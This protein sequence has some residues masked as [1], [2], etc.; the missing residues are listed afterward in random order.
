MDIEKIKAEGVYEA[1]TAA[2]HSRIF[3]VGGLLDKLRRNNFEDLIDN[4]NKI[5]V[6]L[7]EIEAL[8]EELQK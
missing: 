4:M 3:S 6:I 2:I 5:N 1:I 7:R 8:Y